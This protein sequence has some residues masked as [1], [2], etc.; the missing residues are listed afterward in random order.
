MAGEGNIDE[1]EEIQ[2]CIPKKIRGHQPKRS[3]VN[4]LADSLDI[5]TFVFRAGWLVKNVHTAFDY[6]YNSKKKDRISGKVLAGWSHLRESD[7]V[8]AYPPSLDSVKTETNLL[9]QFVLT[10]FHDDKILSYKVK[11]MLTAAIM[12]NLKEFVAI[13][14]DDPKN[15]WENTKHPF[16]ATIHHARNELQIDDATFDK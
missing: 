2:Y 5:Q 12:N 15:R 7:L 1:I 11:R 4:Q 8:T 14:K 16:L 3:S 13:V 9:D 6:I 10:L